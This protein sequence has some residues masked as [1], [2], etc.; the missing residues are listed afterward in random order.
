MVVIKMLYRNGF[1]HDENV[2]QL[3]QAAVRRGLSHVSGTGP[4]QLW[5]GPGGEVL[6]LSPVSQELNLGCTVRG[7]VLEI[8]WSR[9]GKSKMVRRKQQ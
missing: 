9:E 4:R 7:P 1:A 8:V 2:G 3:T 5:K 6:E